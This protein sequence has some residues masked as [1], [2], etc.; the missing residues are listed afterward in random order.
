MA[1]SSTTADPLDFL[2]NSRVDPLPSTSPLTRVFVLDNEI[3][4][5]V[6]HGFLESDNIPHNVE[7]Y[8]DLAYD[9]LFQATR[10]WGAIVT[11]QEDAARA[12][13]LIEQ[14]IAEF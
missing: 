11:R 13:A 6:I 7:C 8:R 10:G 14:A 3:Q 5:Q 2:D 1:D 9:G 12:L 4:A